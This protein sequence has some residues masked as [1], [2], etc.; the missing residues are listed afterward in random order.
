MFLSAVDNKVFKCRRHSQNVRTWTH[1]ISSLACIVLHRFRASGLRNTNI[2]GCRVVGS[3][4]LHNRCNTGC[5]GALGILPRIDCSDFTQSIY[6]KIWAKMLKAMLFQIT[7][8]PCR[9]TYFP[10][11]NPINSGKQRL[12]AYP[13]FLAN[14]LS[15]YRRWRCF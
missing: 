8:K 14:F 6:P 10:T 1:T 5:L 12:S 3:C 9:H 2:S 11:W 13:F 4:F 15:F 7:S